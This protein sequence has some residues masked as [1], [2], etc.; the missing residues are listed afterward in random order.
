MLNAGAGEVP[1]EGTGAV[2][3]C[4]GTRLRLG[5]ARVSAGGLVVLQGHGQVD[6]VDGGLV[7]AGWWLGPNSMI[8]LV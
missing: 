8:I 5:G 2:G 6:E 7:V 4:P 1:A 3:G